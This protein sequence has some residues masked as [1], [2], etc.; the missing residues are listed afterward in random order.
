MQ[1]MEYFFIKIGRRVFEDSGNT[2]ITVVSVV[3]QHSGLFKDCWVYFSGKQMLT[4][5]VII[6]DERH[7]LGQAI[8]IQKWLKINRIL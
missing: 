5:N 7:K 8:P 1:Q 6:M 3:K 4:S 2:F